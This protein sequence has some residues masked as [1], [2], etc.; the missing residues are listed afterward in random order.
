M[1]ESLR[2]DSVKSPARQRGSGEDSGEFSWVAQVE[3]S[4]EEGSSGRKAVTK[5][6]RRVKR[7]PTG[8]QTGRHRVRNRADS[9]LA[10]RALLRPVPPLDSVPPL[11]P[12]RPDRTREQPRHELGRARGAGL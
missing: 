3:G 4:R 11:G 5:E 2:G 1:P 7:L 12:A 6:G 10:L 9:V 8:R